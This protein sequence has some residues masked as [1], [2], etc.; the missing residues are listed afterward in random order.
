MYMDFWKMMEFYSKTKVVTGPQAQLSTDLSATPDIDA[1]NEFKAMYD[2]SRKWDIYHMSLNF[3]T[4]NIQEKSITQS[5]C[6]TDFWSMVH[7]CPLY[8]LLF[9][10]Y[11]YTHISWHILVNLSVVK[12]A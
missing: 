3:L 1:Y 10:R 7:V 2:I 12:G 9:M 5:K 8:T 4:R 11:N 6:T